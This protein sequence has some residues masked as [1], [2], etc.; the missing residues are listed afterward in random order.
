MPLTDSR[1]ISKE[2]FSDPALC[3]GGPQRGVRDR[4]RARSRALDLGP[5]PGSRAPD[6]GPGPGPWIWGPRAQGPWA[7]L[8]GLG[9]IVILG[10]A[11]INLA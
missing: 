4:T 5:R 2:K 1:P 9:M 11:I 10:Q 7:H 3:P 8:F 6:L